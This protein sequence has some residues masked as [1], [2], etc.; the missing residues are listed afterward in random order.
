[1]LCLVYYVLVD[2]CSD[3]SYPPLCLVGSVLEPPPSLFVDMF[4]FL[5]LLLLD[6]YYYKVI[7]LIVLHWM[8]Y[9]VLSGVLFYVYR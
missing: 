5:F 1:M 4:C 7:R 2:Y 3:K 9:V 8:L 6:G